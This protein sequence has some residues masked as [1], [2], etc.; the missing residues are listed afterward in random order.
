MI[1]ASHAFLRNTRQRR[2]QG[3]RSQRLDLKVI[4]LM[5]KSALGTFWSDP[6]SRVTPE[7]ARGKKQ[8]HKEARALTWG[9]ETS[10]DVLGTHPSHT[11]QWAGCLSLSVKT[12]T[13]VGNHEP[14]AEGEVRGAGSEDL[15]QGP[16][17][18]PPPRPRL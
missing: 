16:P 4:G 17:H 5:R 18:L 6:I 7:D 10:S 1:P 2:G 14:L 3:T 13:F 9:V 8:D 15:I 12:V 11:V